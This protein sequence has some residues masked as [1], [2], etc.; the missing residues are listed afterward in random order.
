LGDVD[1]ALRGLLGEEAPLSATTVS[2]LK[3]QGHAEWQ[4][5]AS[6]PLADLEVVDLW[7]DGVSVK[8]GLAQAKAAVLVVLAGLSDGRKARLALVP[9]HR[10]SPEAW[11]EVLRDRQARGLPAP[12]LVIGDGHLGIGAGLRHGSPEAQAQRG[13]THRIVNA[14]DGVRRRAR[15]T[16][17]FPS[18]SSRTP[19]PSRRRSG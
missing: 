8:A 2:R 13:W 11:A 18:R 6:R 9:G 16:P 10:A 3:A 12:T 17:G 15:P 4:A 1:P 14:F 7:V 19:P 5:W